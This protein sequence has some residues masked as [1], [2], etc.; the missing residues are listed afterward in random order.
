M[1]YL[2]CPSL[3]TRNNQ[4]E[5]VIPFILWEQME[6]MLLANGLHA[7]VMVA[8]YGRAGTTKP[9]VKNVHLLTI[10]GDRCIFGS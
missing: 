5:A 6:C 7:Y 10:K 1:M 3:G 9:N 8:V 2:A 4:L